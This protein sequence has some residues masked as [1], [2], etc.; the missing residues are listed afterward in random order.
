MENQKTQ[1]Q[2]K[3]YKTL[4]GKLCKIY[5]SIQV[6][7]TNQKNRTTCEQ[8]WNM[9]KLILDELQG[10]KAKA[11]Y[12]TNLI[13]NLSRD[14]TFQYGNGLSQRQLYDMRALARV[15][16]KKELNGQ[17]NWNH[18]KVLATVNDPKKRKQLE[19]FTL[20]KDI[21]ANLLKR[22][23]ENQTA[24]LSA[25]PLSPRNGRTGLYK[26]VATKKEN[27]EVLELDCGFRVLESLD[28]KRAA[29]LQA[30]QFVEEVA[31]KIKPAQIKPFERYCYHGYLQRVI[32]GDTVV[33]K[34]DL[35][36]GGGVLHKLRLRGVLAPELITPAGKKFKQYLSRKLKPGDPIKIQ[37][38]R[39]DKY[40][41]YV[42]DIFDKVGNFLNEELRQ[43]SQRG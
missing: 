10:G 1:T 8:Y 18:Y 39:E 21:D 43:Y 38:Y 17:L 37:T 26:V 36:L 29:K 22:M 19:L 32:D 30:G 40:G 31:H 35:G 42:A 4:L 34:V 28:K 14:L 24:G 2:N 23:V 5:Q 25:K 9:G 27:T 11:K 20:E 41:R 13:A 7:G 33:A 16:N 15:Y 12:G 6:M 3:N